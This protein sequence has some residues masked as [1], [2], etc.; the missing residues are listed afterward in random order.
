MKVAIVGYGPVGQA[1]NR[2]LSN[3]DIKCVVQDPAR[4]PSLVI[5]DWSDIHLAFICVPTDTGEDGR[6]DTSVLKKAVE[7]VEMNAHC[8]IRSTIGP[9]QV[10]EFPDCSVM[11]EFIRE[12]TWAEDVDSKL[13]PCIIGTQNDQLLTD[14]ID[15]LKSKQYLPVISSP[16]EAMM[17]KLSINTFL[18]MKVAFA[19]DM[20][21]I[22]GQLGMN[23][24][25][26]KELVMLDCRV[27]KTHW[28]VPGPSGQ[29]GFGGKCF[30]KDT[31]HFALLSPAN[32]PLAHEITKYALGQ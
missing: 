30:P 13:T 12:R 28:D 3:C 27:G 2:L 23:Y 5:S 6:L 18:A 4:D 8:V 32:T 10:S 20:W 9:D 25:V 26:I 11:P 22:C 16:R 29:F 31:K 21:T 24:N 1:T 15:A 19:N 7:S 17:A 14:F